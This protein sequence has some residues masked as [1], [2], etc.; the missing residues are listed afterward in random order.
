M[1][2][3]VTQTGTGIARKTIT[4]S[5]MSGTTMLMP[6]PDAMQEFKVETASATAQRGSSTA[7]AA[8]PAAIIS[9]GHGDPARGGIPSAILIFY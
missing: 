7:V 5:F 2:I 4:I 9:D 3:T 1:E 8:A 6:F